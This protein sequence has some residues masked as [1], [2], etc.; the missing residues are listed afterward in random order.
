MLEEARQQ[1][2]LA[3]RRTAAVSD[4]KVSKAA[5]LMVAELRRQWQ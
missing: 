4:E 1:A 3:A 2:E 5:D